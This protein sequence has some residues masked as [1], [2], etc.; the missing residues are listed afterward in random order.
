M[1]LLFNAASTAL[2]DRNEI[3]LSDDGPPINT[4][5]FPNSLMRFPRLATTHTVDGR[6]LRTSRVYALARYVA[7]TPGRLLPSR[8]G[9]FAAPSRARPINTATFPNSLMPRLR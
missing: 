6:L 1:S 3:S 7:L 9:R 4:A 8:T 2:P 5:T